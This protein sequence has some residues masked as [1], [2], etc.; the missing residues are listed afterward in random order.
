MHQF[1]ECP[2]RIGMWQIGL[3]NSLSNKLPN[4]PSRKRMLS[5]RNK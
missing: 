5:Q 2:N 1:R 4:S 3:G